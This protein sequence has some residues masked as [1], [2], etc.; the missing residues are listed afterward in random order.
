MTTIKKTEEKRYQEFEVIS[1]ELLVTDPCYEKG[2]WCSGDLEN[3]LPGI[4]QASVM[5]LQDPDWGDRVAEL[6]I[7]HESIKDTDAESIDEW[8]PITVGVDSGQAG[9]FDPQFYPNGEPGEYGDKDTFYGRAC[10]A[11]DNPHDWGI[12]DGH[13]VVSQSGFGDGAYACYV[14]RDP[15]G[16]VIAAKIVFISDEDYEDDH[17][18]PEPC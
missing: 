17:E 2:T 10:E 16:R 6:V 1:N 18:L 8:V 5:R 13:G 14:T 12:V 3:V 15:Q 7:C 11:T 4:W 9:F